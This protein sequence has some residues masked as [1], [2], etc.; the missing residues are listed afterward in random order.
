MTYRPLLLCVGEGQGCPEELASSPVEALV[1]I[2]GVTLN[3]SPC[4]R[5]HMGGVLRM[6][7]QLRILRDVL[8]I[9]KLLRKRCVNVFVQHVQVWTCV[10]TMLSL[11]GDWI[12]KATEIRP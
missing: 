1:L 9:C 3:G 11:S 7:W 5:E 4:L 2:G 8:F 10:H 12:V 6:F